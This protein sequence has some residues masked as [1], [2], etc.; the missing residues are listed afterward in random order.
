MFTVTVLASE[1]PDL[2]LLPG[3]LNSQ[4][5]LVYHRAYSHSWAGLALAA[6]L[7]TLVTGVL[8]PH[9]PRKKV[10]A[11]AVL[12]MLV[13]VA[14]DSLTTYGTGL[15]MPFSQRMLALDVFFG[16]D[17]PL[18]I[19]LGTG[20][21]LYF[22]RGERRVVRAAVM[23]ALLYTAGRWGV[24]WRLTD[25]ARAQLPGTAF[26]VL[27]GPALRWTVVAAK[28]ESYAVGVIDPLSGKIKFQTTYPKNLKHPLVAGISQNPV[29]ASYLQAARYPWAQIAREP[30]GWRIKL[31]DLRLWPL[32]GFNAVVYL[33][34]SGKVRNIKIGPQK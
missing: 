27:P 26:S 5:Q 29:V 28:G 8:E 25:A 17:I 4:A 6:G 32:D 13:H 22:W 14:F 1:I 15:L 31:S 34:E 9:L 16:V 2:D 12:A 24:H 30:D 33:D 3:L 20:C 21:S 7:L 23:L 18:L 11:W 19:L 10:L